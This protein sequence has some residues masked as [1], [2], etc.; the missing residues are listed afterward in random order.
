MAGSIIIELEQ[1][2]R[3]DELLYFDM[4]SQFRPGNFSVYT[5]TDQIEWQLLFSGGTGDYKKW[6]RIDGAGIEAQYLR[7]DYAEENAAKGMTE[8]VIY[9]SPRQP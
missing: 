5:S 2:T 7:I 1:A 8:M 4:S 9:G 3:L 6:R